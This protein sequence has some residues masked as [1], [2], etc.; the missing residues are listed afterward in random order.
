MTAQWLPG[1]R[2][3][4]AP[5]FDPSRAVIVRDEPSGKDI[6]RH[7]SNSTDTK[8]LVALFEM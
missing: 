3:C 2:A 6:L 7:Q 5:P 4:R 8:S 1:G